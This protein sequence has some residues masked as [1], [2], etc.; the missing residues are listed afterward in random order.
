MRSECRSRDP[1]LVHLSRCAAAWIVA[2]AAGP[3]SAEPGSGTTAG[4]WGSPPAGM[5]EIPPGECSKPVL[6]HEPVTR[7][8]IS[9]DDCP[10]RQVRSDGFFMDMTEVTQRAY[11]EFVAATGRPAPPHWLDGKMPEALADLPIYNVSWDDAD[12]YCTWKHRRLPRE[13]EW[14]RAAR[15]GLGK[16]EGPGD[17]SKPGRDTARDRASLGPGPVRQHPANPFGLYDMAGN[18]AEWCVNW[19]NPTSKTVGATWFDLTS[20]E[21]GATANFREGAD[22]LYRIVRGSP[23][24]DRSWVKPDRRAPDLGFRCA[25][26]FPDH[27]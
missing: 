4:W 12:A 19:S 18:V 14:E 6:D 5:V 20:Y 10:A 27:P 2:L 11:A 17:D 26:D 25:A 7:P 8:L 24:D 13:E 22:R 3:A 1:A 21:S 23:W 9:P 15:G 16:D